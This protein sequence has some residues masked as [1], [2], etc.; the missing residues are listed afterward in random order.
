MGI[1]EQIRIEELRK[2]ELA[3]ASDVLGKAFAA[4]PSSPVIYLDKSDVARRMQIV[5]RAMLGHLPGQVFVTKI[6]GGIVGTM[7]IVE[8]PHCQMSPFQGLRMLPTLL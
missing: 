8:W 6:D 4:Q 1:I 7:R 3:Q 5:F 2:E